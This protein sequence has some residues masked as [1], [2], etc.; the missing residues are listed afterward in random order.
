[1]LIDLYSS[2]IS[3]REGKS[4]YHTPYGFAKYSIELGVT[5]ATVY[6]DTIYVVPE[7]RRSRVGTEIA[8]SV[9]AIAKGFGCQRLLG[10]VAPSAN[11]SHESMLGLLHYGMRL[12]KA[13]E[14]MVYFVKDI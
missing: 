1:M 11:G 13:T 5:P 2:Y 12:F 3:E 10:S 14:D 6:I 9:I 8:D 4:L 7:K